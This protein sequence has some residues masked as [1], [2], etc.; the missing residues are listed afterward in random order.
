MS[1]EKTPEPQ[2]QSARSSLAMGSARGPNWL[3][4]VAKQ[5]IQIE[6]MRRAIEDILKHDSDQGI[7]DK[8]TDAGW[9][10]SPALRE[11]MQT[12][13]ESLPNTGSQGRA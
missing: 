10:Q 11:K 5:L 2:G 8:A 9:E 6:A 7:V 12:L 13:K 4:T 1:V 3:K